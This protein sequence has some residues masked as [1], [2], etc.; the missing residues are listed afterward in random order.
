MEIQPSNTNQKDSERIVEK[1][2]VTDEPNT[3]ITEAAKAEITRLT[4][5]LVSAEFADN[6]IAKGLSRYKNDPI[7]DQKF[8]ELISALD[9]QNLSRKYLLRIDGEHSPFRLHNPTDHVSYLYPL[10]IPRGA[11]PIAY[12]WSS[13]STFRELNVGMFVKFNEPMF[14]KGEF[15]FLLISVAMKVAKKGKD[16]PDPNQVDR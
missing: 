14:I 4:P 10:H 3:E 15:T 12:E 11:S 13:D 6:G 7:L 9:Q 5:W 1:D 8:S 16:G 2:S